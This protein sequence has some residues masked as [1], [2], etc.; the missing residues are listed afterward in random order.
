MKLKLCKFLSLTIAGVISFVIN[1]I[2]YVQSYEYYADEVGTDIE[3][4]SDYVVAM[5]VS[6]SIIAAGVYAIVTI[7]KDINNANSFNSILGSVSSALVS[8][9]SLGVLF[10]ALNKGKAFEDYTLYLYIGL[11]SLALFAYFIFSYFESKKQN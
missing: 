8:F 7:K 4:N 2:N 11:F 10:K 5:L 6:L 1:L 3:F 9:Y